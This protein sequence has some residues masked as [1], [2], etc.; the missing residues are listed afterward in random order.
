MNVFTVSILG[1]SSATPTAER[2]S[3]SQLVNINGSL[4]LLDCGEG[5]QIQLRR[6]KFKLNRLKNIFISHLHGDHFFGLVGLL[7]TLHLFGRTES[8][9]IY[10]P[11]GL[12][13]II[14]L[15]M[16]VSQTILNY[17][18]SFVDTKD[19]GF[20]QLLD[21]RSFT[22]S[23]FPLEHRIPTTGFIIREKPGSARIRKN[24]LESENIP[25][26][27]IPGIKAGDDFVTPDGRRIPNNELTY[28]PPPPRTY[29]YCS[30]TRFSESYLPYIA[31]ANLLYHESTFMHE[32]KEVAHEKFHSTAYEAG[33]VAK[34]SGAK[35][36]I[37]GH[38]STRYKDL[39]ELEQEAKN[40]FPDTIA[41]YD[42]M[43]IEIL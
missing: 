42:G 6:H 12:E 3:S 31:N 30:D 1:S 22:V 37:L 11:P 16:E 18:L 14:K 7:S 9:R 26:D 40:V 29:A 5:T 41:A 34:M 23:S 15:Q 39:H 28:S 33:M 20:Y 4:L 32:L 43:C 25:V 36:L 38:Y 10:S 21:T 27:K 24:M 17:K 19:D 2:N 35:K 8:L 13:E